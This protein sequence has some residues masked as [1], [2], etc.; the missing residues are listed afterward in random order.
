VRAPS[1]G[2]WLSTWTR[3]GSA[4]DLPAECSFPMKG[5]QCG[6]G[7]MIGLRGL[8]ARAGGG[9]DR[10]DCQGGRKSHGSSDRESYP[11]G[12]GDGLETSDE[13][14]GHAGV[15][16]TPRRLDGRCPQPVQQS[17]DQASGA[18][19]LKDGSGD[20]AAKPSALPRTHRV[21]LRRSRPGGGTSAEEPN[22]PLRSGRSKATATRSVC[23][24]EV[25]RRDAPSVH[26]C[27]TR[28]K[29]GLTGGRL[30]RSSVGDPLRRQGVAIFGSNDREAD[31]EPP[32]ERV[33]DVCQLAEREVACAGL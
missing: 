2:S 11:G 27:C 19:K 16:A 23:R 31:V 17:K 12:Y 5:T 28:Q 15:G 13:G 10:L 32:A 1:Q 21:L 24:R 8:A 18:A 26:P 7:G 4:A 3:S 6:P 22:E 29:D 20:L 14:V 9:V 30:L 25:R 33:G